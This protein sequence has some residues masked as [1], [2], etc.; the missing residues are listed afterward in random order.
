MAETNKT[1]QHTVD[2]KF[3]GDTFRVDISTL[4]G[5]S[6]V[7]EVEEKITGERWR[8]HFKASCKYRYISP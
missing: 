6:L 1:F 3:H 4:G 5:E 8:G 7:I 2:A